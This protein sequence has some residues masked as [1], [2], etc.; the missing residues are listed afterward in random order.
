MNYKEVITALMIIVITIALSS[1]AIM[2][3]QVEYKKLKIIELL[4]QQAMQELKS[5]KGE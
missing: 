3:M 1:L 5:I 2:R 4:Q